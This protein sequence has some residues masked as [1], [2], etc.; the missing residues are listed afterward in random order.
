[1]YLQFV[2][3]AIYIILGKHAEAVVNTV[4]YAQWVY[5]VLVFVGLLLLRYKRPNMR[6]PF[7]VRR[8]VLFE[9]FW[10]R[11]RIFI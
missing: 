3:T 6:R 2:C 5:F 7:K 11:I 9:W 1:M 8:R 4:M 10:L